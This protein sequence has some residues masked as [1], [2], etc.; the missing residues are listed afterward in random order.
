MSKTTSFWD[1]YC[2]IVRPV[3]AADGRITGAE[4]FYENGLIISVEHGLSNVR[5]HLADKYYVFLTEDDK[6]VLSPRRKKPKSDTVT[7]LGQSRLSQVVD[8]AEL[9]A[10]CCALGSLPLSL[11]QNPGIR[12][13]LQSAWPHQVIPSASTIT[14]RVDALYEKSIPSMILK[15]SAARR[16][17]FG[18]TKIAICCD[19]WTSVSKKGHI[20]VNAFAISPSMTLESFAVGCEPLEYPHDGGRLAEKVVEMLSGVGI[21]QRDLISV[22]SDSEASAIRADRIITDSFAAIITCA[23]HKLNLC[24]KD[25]AAVPSFKK[26]LDAVV[27]VANFFQYPKRIEALE[28]K[29]RALK[30]PNVR[31]ITIC[32]T[33]W[34]YI[35]DVISRSLRNS[36]VVAALTIEDLDLPDTKSK[37]NWEL[38]KKLF[39]DSM[40]SLHLMLPLLEKISS[41]MQLLSSHHEATLSRVFYYALEIY[42]DAT[43]LMEKDSVACKEFAQQMTKSIDERFYFTPSSTLFRF[44]EIMDPVVASA[45]IREQMAGELQQE[46]RKIRDDLTAIFFPVTE[47]VQRPNIFGETVSSAACAKQERFKSEFGEYLALLQTSPEPLT[48]SCLSWW[49][50]HESSF[51]TVAFVA[52][53]VLCAQ[54]SSSEAERLFSIAAYIVNKWR[55]RLTGARANRL[56]FLSRF[57]RE[58]VRETSEESADIDSSHI[59]DDLEQEP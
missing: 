26:V 39:I 29:Q 32:T 3:K 44:A 1:S 35:S 45:T 12:M 59:L 40:P 24:L 5:Q 10:R 25:A 27:E 11:V 4:F 53:N 19:C 20:G 58:T 43:Q 47:E 33:R 37:E 52:R 15:L 57:L 7:T 23:C 46:L 31:F 16:S 50:T 48:M 38:M 9:L 56:I 30:L 8:M 42:N 41:Y 17:E 18:N 34:N 51:P 49:R 6:K 36:A 55:N 28:R 14:N 21:N 2:N 54:A 22:T 13:L